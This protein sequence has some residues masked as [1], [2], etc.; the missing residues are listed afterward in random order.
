MLIPFLALMF[1][2]KTKVTP[3]KG[4][5][6]MIFMQNFTPLDFQ[7][8]IKN[9]KNTNGLLLRLLCDYSKAGEG[10]ERGVIVLCASGLV[11]LCISSSY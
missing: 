8:K 1:V 9:Y 5:A 10:V 4:A 11:P 3:G 7:A 6:E 2:A